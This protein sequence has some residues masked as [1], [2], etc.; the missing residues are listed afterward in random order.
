MLTGDLLGQ[1]R[2]YIDVCCGE[3]HRVPRTLI[4]VPRSFPF[5]LL[6]RPFFLDCIAAFHPVTQPSIA[7]LLCVALTYSAVTVVE[8]LPISTNLNNLNMA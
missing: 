6:L 5:V 8:G 1:T 4:V 7:F 3:A 2:S